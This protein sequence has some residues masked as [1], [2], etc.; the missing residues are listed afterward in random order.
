MRPVRP[1]V[2]ALPITQVIALHLNN[3]TVFVARH[4]AVAFIGEFMG[5][6]KTLADYDSAPSDLTADTLASGD[7]ARS[8]RDAAGT[9]SRGGAKHSRRLHSVSVDSGF[10]CNPDES[11]GAA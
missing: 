5:A 4:E 11:G 7:P 2:K 3:E 10:Y 6:L 8:D 9:A 1:T